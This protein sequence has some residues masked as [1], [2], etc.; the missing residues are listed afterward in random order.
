MKYVI[1][2][3]GKVIGKLYT[4]VKILK[5]SWPRRN[6]T[7]LLLTVPNLRIM[8]SLIRLGFKPSEL[9][10]PSELSPREDTNNGGNP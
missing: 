5:E 3:C 9:I 2:R 8:D 4:S 6:I 7:P 1:Y 10:M